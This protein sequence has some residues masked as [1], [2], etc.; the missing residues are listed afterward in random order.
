M[1]QISQMRPPKRKWNS[2][3]N[4]NFEHLS[5]REFQMSN[6]IP[7]EKPRGS[8]SVFP[9]HEVQFFFTLKALQEATIRHG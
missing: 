4:L 2:G 8:R 9:N 5:L 3:I 1:S 7:Y 6:K